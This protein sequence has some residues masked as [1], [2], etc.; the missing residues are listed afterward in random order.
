MVIPISEVQAN[1]AL[2]GKNNPNPTKTVTGPTP[3]GEF[4]PGNV[5]TK[6]DAE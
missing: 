4:A 1:A 6:E 5:P 2:E 3:I